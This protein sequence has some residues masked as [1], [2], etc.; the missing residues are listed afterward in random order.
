[1]SS[2]NESYIISCLEKGFS[3]SQI[4]AALGVTQSA[5]SQLIEAK[6]LKSQLQQHETFDKIDTNLNK[7]ELKLSDTLLKMLNQ[8]GTM[9]NPMQVGSL[10]KTVNSARRRST[11]EGR[12]LPGSA[13]LV[14]IKLPEHVKARIVVSAE[15]QLLE[16]DGQSLATLPSSELR[17]LLKNED[18]TELDYIPVSKGV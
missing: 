1:M 17:G 5:V 14:A 15:N 6:N 13:K 3:E 16:I 7:I 8:P 4:A 10:L 18:A 9:L 11:G 12:E 2:K